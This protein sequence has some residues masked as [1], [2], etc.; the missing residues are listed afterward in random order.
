MNHL[1]SSKSSIRDGK[2]TVRPFVR[3]WV[4]VTIQLAHCD[5]FGIDHRVMNAVF[6][7]QTLELEQRS[8]VEIPVKIC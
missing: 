3:D 2:N 4:E 1:R 5:S 8:N 6:V 7:Q